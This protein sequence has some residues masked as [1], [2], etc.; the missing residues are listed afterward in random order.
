MIYVYISFKSL[1]LK[2]LLL[3]ILLIT[4]LED[5]FLRLYLLNVLFEIR[6]SACLRFGAT[7]GVVVEACVEF[8]RLPIVSHLDSKA[9]LSPVVRLRDTVRIVVKLEIYSRCV[10]DVGPLI[11]QRV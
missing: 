8:K 11:V 3:L 6:V 5:I 4:Q 10:G 1:S 9:V 7:V 2:L